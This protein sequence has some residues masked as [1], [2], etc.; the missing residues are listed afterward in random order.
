VGGLGR[1]RPRDRGAAAVEFA[2]VLP[3]LLIIIFGI[4]DFG[5]M[6][7]AKITATEAARE[8]ARAMALYDQY[9][10]EQRVAEIGEGVGG[11]EVVSADDC[12]PDPAPGD[13]AVMV[14][15]DD[16]HFVTP[17]GVIIG[18]FTGSEFL[19]G[20]GVMPCLP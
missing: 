7:N 13:D 9:E 20:K 17:L 19:Y 8:G 12:G 3:V 2:L 1:V 4:I 5:R 15:R 16:F 14:V 18:V 10:G 11:L 6:L